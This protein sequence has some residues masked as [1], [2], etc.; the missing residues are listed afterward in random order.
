MEAGS[1]EHAADRKSG[2]L[3]EEISVEIMDAYTPTRGETLP[4]S[5]N[6]L[7]VGMIAWRTKPAF[8]KVNSITGWVGVKY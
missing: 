5:R 1:G 6:H 3:R 2:E 4:K 8:A 7:A